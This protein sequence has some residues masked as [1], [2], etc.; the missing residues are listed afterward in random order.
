MRRAVW[1]SEAIRAWIL[2]IGLLLILTIWP[3]RLW[4]QTIPGEGGGVRMEVSRQVDDG[5]DLIQDFIA[6]YDRLGS[7]DLYVEELVSGRYIDLT[8]FDDQNVLLFHRYIDLGKESLPGKVRIPLGLDLEVGRSY[9]LFFM[10]AF[11]GY[12]LGLQNIPANGQA[13]PC[14]GALYMND[15]SAES[16]HLDMTLNYRQPIG[17]QTSLMLMLLLA[18]LTL[19]AERCV[20][21]RARRMAGRERIVTV[22]EAIRAVLAPLFFA[23]V[24]ALLLLLLLLV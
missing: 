5:H 21:I 4:Q 2:A 20:A 9:R 10:G 23:G 3:L 7:V 12:T 16:W 13:S 19:L 24:L 22:G 15:T 11:S 14:F 8:V 18:V 1:T 6:Q 17:K